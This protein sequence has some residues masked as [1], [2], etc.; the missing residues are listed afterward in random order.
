MLWHRFDIGQNSNLFR[1]FLA[2]S[3]LTIFLS[4]A[5]LAYFIS[6]ELENSMLETAADEGAILIDGFLGPSLQTLASSSHLQSDAIEKLDNL[7]KTTMGGRTKALK[8]WLRDGTLVYATDKRLVGQKFPSAKLDASFQGK[9]F[10]SFAST[11]DQAHETERQFPKP[12]VE[13]YAPIYRA[14]TREIIAVGEVYNSGARLAAEVSAMRWTAVGIVGSMTAPMIVALLLLVWRASGVVRNQRHYLHSRIHEARSLAHQN[15]QLRQASEAIQLAAMHSNEQLLGQIGQDLHDGP[16]QLV[17]VLAL[18]LSELGETSSATNSGL[19]ANVT[20]L[21]SS[22]LKELREISTG[23]VLPELGGLTCTET[24]EFAIR[25]HERNTA[26]LVECDLGAMSFKPEPALQVCM[27]RVLQECL[28][29]A[30]TH[31]AGREQ[32]VT[33]SETASLITI[34]VS[35]SVASQSDAKPSS[36]HRTGLGLPGLRRRVLAHGGSFVAQLSNGQ[37]VVTVELPTRVLQEET[38]VQ[39]AVAIS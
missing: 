19:F 27:F 16:I 10:G 28:N 11:D 15:E 17:S 24:L 13:I 1:E 2:A 9:S 38:A 23:L 8:V 22:I 21:T 4:M 35:N 26:T 18:K 33:A 20:T 34:V 37:M 5:S 3:A 25:H 14:G 6:R 39:T 29:N 12:L 7:L 31:G 32:R 36:S 30:Y